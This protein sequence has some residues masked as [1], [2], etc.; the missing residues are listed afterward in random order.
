[1]AAPL[2]RAFDWA[3]DVQRRYSHVGGQ[4]LAAGVALYGFLA[5]FALLVLSVAVLGFLSVGNGHLARD[6]AHDLGLTGDAARIV[7]KSVRA[8][9]RSRS[10]TTIVGI[11]GI[12]W[13]GTSFAMS[14]GNAYN[15][16]WRVTDR[17]I[18]ERLIGLAWLAGA[19]VLLVIA[20]W[21]T[22]LWDLLPGFLAP[23]VIIVSL[24]GN[25]ALLLFTSWLLPNREAPW[26]SLVVPALLGAIALEVLKVLGAY[27]VPHYVASSSELYGAIGVVFA[28]L[29]WLMFFGRLVVYVA[30]IE[31]HRAEREPQPS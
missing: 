1:V 5:L 15:A 19:A 7:T 11:V 12:V 26:R 30:V 9:R 25:T 8:A 17:G 16:A 2:R 23:L 24:A 22:A 31:A 13:L 4:T 14:I 28:L 3:R 6:I 10:L 27:V 21:A 29:L 18:R 20:G